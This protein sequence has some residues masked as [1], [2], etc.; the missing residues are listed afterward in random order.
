MLPTLKDL[1]DRIATLFLKP[2]A[3]DAAC[4]VWLAET[5]RNNI[6]LPQEISPDHRAW[7]QTLD[8]KAASGTWAPLPGGN[9]LDGVV[10]GSDERQSP[11]THPLFAGGLPTLLPKGDYRL[12]WTPADGELAAI[13]WALGQYTFQRYHANG[14]NGIK[15]LSLPDGADL[16]RVIRIAA[17]TWLGRDLINTPANDFGPAELAEAAR[18]VAGHY[19]AGFRVIEGDDLL[20][21]NFPLIHAVGRA[22]TRAP[23]LIDLRWGDGKGPKVTLIGKG[24]CFDTGGLDIKPG[25]GMLL[26]KKDM[27]GAAA[28]LSL[29]AMIMGEGLP[30]RLRLLIPAA[31]NSISG[32]AFRPGDILPSRGGLNVEIGNTDAEGRLVLAD[33]LALAD[34]EEPDHVISFAT[35]TGAARVALGPDLPPVY[36]TDAAFANALTETGRRL[37]DPMW[38]MPLWQPYDQL[39]D[40]RT[41]DINSIYSEPFAGSIMAALFLKRFVKAARTYT[42]FDIYGWVPRPQP[43]KPV[44]GEPQCARAVFDHLRGM[45]PKA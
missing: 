31:E 40:S 1:S 32:N 15:R 6:S 23:R 36:S 34:E 41:G 20:A 7:L 17:A 18:S 2:G 33:A 27:G 28:A 24:I 14:K 43:G 39:L 19:G 45:F 21:E 10:A 42:H 11:A 3:Q 38:P 30:I 22:S 44:G 13:A 37:G 9:G 5:V 26:M 4:P 29:A 8:F 35:L 16:E 25:S 12:G